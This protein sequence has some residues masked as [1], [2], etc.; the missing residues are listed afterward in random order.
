MALVTE[1]LLN[2]LC[3][4]IEARGTVVWFDPEQTYL[5]LAQS[6]ESK[7]VAQATVHHYDPERGIA[8]LRRQLESLWQDRTDP[9]RLVIYVPAAQSKANHA[10][11]EF[12]VA[13]TVMCPGQQPP[14]CNTALASVTRRAMEAA[15]PLA[16]VDEVVR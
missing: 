8:W 13:G 16:K 7:T 11:I 3:R 12:E 9:P 1:A 2:L 15:L 14:E 4:Q 6:L 5:E 10:L